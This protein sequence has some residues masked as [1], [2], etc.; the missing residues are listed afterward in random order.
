MLVWF[1]LFKKTSSVEIRKCTELRRS[2][3]A[4]LILLVKNRELGIGGRNG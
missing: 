1:R 4:I 3:A 2:T